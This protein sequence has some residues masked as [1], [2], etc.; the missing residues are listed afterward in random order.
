VGDFVVDMAFGRE[1]SVRG[2]FWSFPIYPLLLFTELSQ[3]RLTWCKHCIFTKK[4][5]TCLP[6]NM[7]VCRH[8]TYPLEKAKTCNYALLE[9]K[10]YREWI[11][12][13]LAFCLGLKAKFCGLALEG[14]PAISHDKPSDWSFTS[15]TFRHRLNT[16]NNFWRIVILWQL[17]MLTNNL[18]I[19]LR[20]ISCCQ[21]C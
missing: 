20:N 6:H 1:D 9:N 4:R 12:M 7:G 2:G 15:F 17:K 11:P 3:W 18:V 16:A 21:W 8:W 10:L 13:M 19:I 14:W 5:A